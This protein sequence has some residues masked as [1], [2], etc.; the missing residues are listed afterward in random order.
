M[1]E[2]FKFSKFPDDTHGRSAS[3]TKRLHSQRDKLDVDLVTVRKVSTIFAIFG[4]GEWCPCRT[5]AW[6]NIS[7]WTGDMT[8][9]SS[10]AE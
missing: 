8:V 10:A 6:S 2:G 9:T 5:A 4:N 3:A 1:V 7:C